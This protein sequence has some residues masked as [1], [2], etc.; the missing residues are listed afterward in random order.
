MPASTSPLANPVTNSESSSSEKAAIALFVDLDGTLIDT[1]VLAEA[2]LQAVRRNPL[3]LFQLPWLVSRGRARFKQEIARRVPVD[4]TLLP[5]Q[6]EVLDYLHACKA[7]G[8]TLILATATDQSWAHAV[9]EHLGIFEAVLASDGV[10]NLKGKGKLAAIEADCHE[11]GWSDF[12]YAGD[13][14]ADLPIWRAARDVYV[15]APSGRLRRSLTDMQRPYNIL[16]SSRAW[17]EAPHTLL[18]GAHWWPN[19]W[20][21]LP[22]LLATLF[23]SGV[24][25]SLLACAFLVC[26]L[27]TWS[28]GFARQMASPS[29][30]DASATRRKRLPLLSAAR[31]CLLTFFA[32]SLV[33]LAALPWWFVPFAWTLWSAYVVDAFWLAEHT[34]WSGASLVCRQLLRVVA[35]ALLL[36]HPISWPSVIAFGLAGVGSLFGAAWRGRRTA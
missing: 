31:W 14:H 11:R 15:V 1:D 23:V 27:F 30:S 24:S 19:A 5:Y 36:P 25:L 35:G 26:V 32:A 28:A 33:S 16:G 17:H 10:R 18:Q 8:Q 21:L 2:T 9:A 34:G 7:E 4:A 29:A 22:A 6:R 20:L 13:A 3:F 12:G